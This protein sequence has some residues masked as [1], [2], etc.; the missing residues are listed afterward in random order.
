MIHLPW[1][2]TVTLTWTSVEVVSDIFASM[3]R[4]LFDCLIELSVRGASSVTNRESRDFMESITS[5]FELGEVAG[6][7]VPLRLANGLRVFYLPTNP[8][9]AEARVDDLIDSGHVATG[10]SL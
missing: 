9:A 10:C 1:E 4:V 2:S 3:W 8:L 5:A 6:E 7:S